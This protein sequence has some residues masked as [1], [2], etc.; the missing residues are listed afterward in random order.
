[1]NRE[2]FIETYGFSIEDM[3]E[4]LKNKRYRRFREMINDLNEADT[5]EYIE[6]QSP[7][8]RILIF[9]MLHKDQAADVFAFLPPEIQEEIINASTDVEVK[10]IIEELYVDDAV[11]MMEE[12]P[13]TVVKRILKTAL[14]AVC[15]CTLHSR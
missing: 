3:D 12:L 6:D 4:Q 15:L 2:S 1:M 5:A 9:R 13:A 8:A 10:S 14:I 7:D 11:D